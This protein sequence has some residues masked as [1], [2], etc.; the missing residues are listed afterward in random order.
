MIILPLINYLYLVSIITEMFLLML[1]F[2]NIVAARRQS[3]ALLAARSHVNIVEDS[4]WVKY[5]HHQLQEVPGRIKDIIQSLEKVILDLDQFKS[6][7]V[8][9]SL[10]RSRQRVNYTTSTDGTILD[11][12]QRFTLTFN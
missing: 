5:P 12:I 2:L 6:Q 1:L 4:L 3:G 8:Y 11:S 7:H 10:Q 9:V